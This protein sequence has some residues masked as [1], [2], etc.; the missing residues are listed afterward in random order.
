M[1]RRPDAES[2]ADHATNEKIPE[3]ARSE[4][5]RILARLAIQRYIRLTKEQTHDQ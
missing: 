5:A 3:P 1:T 4:V 2:R